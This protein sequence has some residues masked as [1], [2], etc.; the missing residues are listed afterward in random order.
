MKKPQRQNRQLAN[1]EMVIINGVGLGIWKMSVESIGVMKE[2][3]ERL[4]LKLDQTF[5]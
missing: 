1:I 4:L 2:G 5:S 3:G